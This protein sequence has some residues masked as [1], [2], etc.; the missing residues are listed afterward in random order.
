AFP[1][2]SV[3]MRV[4]ER[5][6]TARRSPVFA[7]S[8]GRA[9]LRA[10]VGNWRVCAAS[11]AGPAAS[12]LAVPAGPV[13]S[14]GLRQPGV[15]AEDRAPRQ[16]GTGALGQREDQGNRTK[17]A[18]RVAGLLEDRYGDELRRGP[19]GRPSLSKGPPVE[20]GFHFLDHED[21]GRR[22]RI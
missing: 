1:S 21:R 3:R 18:P 9:T 7:W 14:A 17:S 10:R 20:R 2:V 13:A 4:G 15:P 22:N 11:Q 8:S 16:S 19:A 5:R 12:Y 6:P